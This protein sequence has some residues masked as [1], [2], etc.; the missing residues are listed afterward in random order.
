MRESEREVIRTQFYLN[1]VMLDAQQRPALRRRSPSSRTQYTL[2]VLVIGWLAH[3][4]QAKVAPRSYWATFSEIFVSI[5]C[6]CCIVSRSEYI[7]RST[8]SRVPIVQVERIS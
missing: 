6:C 8:S 2:M 7:P 3:L 5:V 1:C 4:G